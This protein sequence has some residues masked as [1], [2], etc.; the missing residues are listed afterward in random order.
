M[1]TKGD[2]AGGS[3]NKITYTNAP[4]TGSQL[5][6]NSY[7]SCSVSNYQGTTAPPTGGGTVTPLD[8]GASIALTGPGSLSKTLQKSTVANSYE[9]QLDQ[10]A[11]TLVP[12]MYTF[13]G[14]GGADVGPFTANYTMPTIF[15]WTDQANITSVN[16]ANGVT[17]HWTGGNPSGY[18]LISGFS[19]SGTISVSFTCTAHVSDGSFMV[20]PVVLLALPPSASA[21]PGGTAIP[22]SLYVETSDYQLFGPPPGL[23]AAVVES[24]FLYG[25]SVTYQ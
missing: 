6:I 19:T 15:T 7:G 23:D 14:T 22:G 10:T 5:D 9:A 21:T 1:T 18:V 25:S 11:T 24:F 3:F 12:G 20:P 17:V 16:R 8:A 4:P 2:L 13:T